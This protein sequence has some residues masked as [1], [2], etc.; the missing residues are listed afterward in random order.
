MLCYA[1]LLASPCH[2]NF[3]AQS[4]LA[5][6]CAPDNKSLKLVINIHQRLINMQYVNRIIMVCLVFDE[7]WKQILV[8]GPT[9]NNITLPNVI[10]SNMMYPSK[11]SWGPVHRPSCPAELYHRTHV[12]RAEN[13][14]EDLPPEGLMTDMFLS[15]QL[16]GSL[17]PCKRFFLLCLNPCKSRSSPTLFLAAGLVLWGRDRGQADRKSVV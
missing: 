14:L 9:V 16:L 5:L 7:W 1:R 12:W 15:L 6:F 2:R 4:D 13:P 3:S 17:S 11:M 8:L 10:F